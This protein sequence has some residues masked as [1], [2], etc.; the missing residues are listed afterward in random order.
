MSTSE[1]EVLRKELADLRDRVVR[2]ET[3]IKVM[4][5]LATLIPVAI[6][7]WNLVRK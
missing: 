6:Q 2:L 4:G 1:I 5:G 3:Y 7:I